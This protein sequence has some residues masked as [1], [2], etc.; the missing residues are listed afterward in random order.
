MGHLSHSFRGESRGFVHNDARTYAFVRLIDRDGTRLASTLHTSVSQKTRTFFVLLGALVAT[1]RLTASSSQPS[2]KRTKLDVSLRQGVTGPVRVIIRTRPGAR[3]ALRKRLRHHGDVIHGE[4][5]SINALTAT[6]HPEDLA[7]LD[8]DNSIAAVSADAIVLS[9]AAGTAA[10]VQ[11]IQNTL[12]PTL[13]LPSG[14]LS[15]WDVG[16]AV[17]D[18][19]LEP[20]A[21]FSGFRFFDFITG[22]FAPSDE[23]GHG[24]HITGLM[25]SNGTLSGGA[26][27]GIAPRARIISL[28]VLDAQGSGLTSTVIRAIEF[29]VA[30]QHRLGI[31]VI[32]LSLG[33]PILQPAQTDPLVQAVESAVRAGIVVVASA[34]NVG[35]N[36]QTGLPG[37]AG[38][39]SPGNAPSAITVGAVD[40]GNTTTRSDDT[41]PTYSSRGPT[42]YD[43][44]AKPDLV[45][46]GQNL[47]SD[48]ARSSTLFAQLPDHQVTTVGTVPRFLR[49]SGTSLSAAVTTGVVALM[50]EANRNVAAHP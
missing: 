5:A 10:G 24:T 46:P 22:A 36:I 9:D 31:D 12:L 37:Y 48:A 23:Y 8:A 20:S 43:A 45:A 13:G 2:P 35:R 6:I 50:I 7:V 14:R 41:I 17:I 11:T 30:N 34:G 26:Y 27:R 3:A 32:N 39:L 15:G 44:L 33:H 16:I 47:V 19:G 49:L 29:A 28:K 18:S 21:D 4:H 1:G 38:I 40:T 42:W 25:A